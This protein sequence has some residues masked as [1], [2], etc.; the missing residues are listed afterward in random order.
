VVVDFSH[1]LP[2]KKDQ[3]QANEVQANKSKDRSL[4]TAEESF[5]SKA[6]DGREKGP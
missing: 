1:A 3:Q 6:G 2:E 5:A 4:E